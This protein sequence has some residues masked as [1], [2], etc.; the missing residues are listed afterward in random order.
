MDHHADTG[1]AAITYTA[2]VAGITLSGLSLNDWLLVISLLLVLVRV[3]VELLRL[4]DAVIRP[5]IRRFRG[6]EAES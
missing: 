3:P 5:L 6:G 2:G 1:S 4:H